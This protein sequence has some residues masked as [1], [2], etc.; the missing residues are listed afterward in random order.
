MVESRTK[1][2]FG[3]TASFSAD[4]LQGHADQAVLCSAASGS[5]DDS[6]SF[7]CMLMHVCAELCLM[8]T[9]AVSSVCGLLFLPVVQ[10]GRAE[11]RP[12]C[13]WQPGSGER[14]VPTILAIRARK[15]RRHDE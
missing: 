2:P 15:R 11:A 3:V 13:Q 5:A 9:L 7:D 12:P 6:V 14:T 1:P 4:L 10:G 8:I